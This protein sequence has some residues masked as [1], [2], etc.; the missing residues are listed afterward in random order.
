MMSLKRIIVAIMSLLISV[1]GMVPVSAVEDE[2]EMVAQSN[3]GD[4]LKEEAEEDS[5]EFSDMIYVP[6]KKRRRLNDD[7]D[8][9]CPSCFF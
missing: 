3:V 1:E 4:A 6:L 2:K 7:S 9:V 5:S 8:L